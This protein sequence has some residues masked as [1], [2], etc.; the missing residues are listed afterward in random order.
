MRG[1]QP[2]GD[3][4]LEPTSGRQLTHPLT[5]KQGRNAG[6]SLGAVTSVT[7]RVSES[8]AMIVSSSGRQQ[9]PPMF[10]ITQSGHLCWN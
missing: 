7:R 3:R 4:L 1:Q 5:L 9:L 2:H 8:K 6:L 10:L